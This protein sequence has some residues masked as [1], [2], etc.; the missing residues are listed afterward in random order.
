MIGLIDRNAMLIMTQSGQRFCY[1]RVEL[2]PMG[3][4]ILNLYPH[5]VLKLENS[6]DHAG[7]ERFA[8]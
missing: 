6:L 3:A 7:A 5:L 8:L 4:E 2:I 1:W